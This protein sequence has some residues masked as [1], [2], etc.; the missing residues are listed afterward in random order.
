MRFNRTSDAVLTLDLTLMVFHVL[1]FNWLL[2]D[3]Y[4]N[5]VF[6]YQQ[7]LSQHQYGMHRRSLFDENVGPSGMRVESVLNLYPAISCTDNYL[8]LAGSP[9]CA[10]PGIDSH[11]NAVGSISKEVMPYYNQSSGDLY[12]IMPLAINPLLLPEQNGPMESVISGNELVP[13]S[14]DVGTCIQSDHSSQ[15]TTPSANESGQESH[16]KR[17][18]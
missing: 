8:K 16:K 9:A 2:S 1:F 12:S 14:S 15:K 3:K 13:C 6:F 7:A 4:N 17:Q 18:V 10:L 11:L 5:F